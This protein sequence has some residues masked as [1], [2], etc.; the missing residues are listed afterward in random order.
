M[1]SLKIRD[2]AG[3]ECWCVTEELCNIKKTEVILRL[4]ISHG[5]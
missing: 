3:D 2:P 1:K 5:H 4:G